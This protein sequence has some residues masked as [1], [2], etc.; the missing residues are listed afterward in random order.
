MPF[1]VFRR[2]QRKLLAVLAIFA[3][4]AFTLDLSLFR[5]RG[6]GGAGE[7]PV[8]FTIYGNPIRRS[9]M[10]GMKFERARANLFMQN[11]GAGDQFFGGTTD[12][13]IRD[14]MIL[15]H[16]ANRMKMPRS[17]DIAKLWLRDATRGQLTPELFDSIYR[18]NFTGEPPFLVSDE[19]LLGD[20]AN[21]V[22]LLKLRSL[23]VLPVSSPL[24]MD[25]SGVT[26]LDI[27]QAYR[28]QNEKVSALA[29][30][31][32]VEDYLDKVPDPKPTELQSFFDKY[33]DQL[34][35]PNRDTPGFKSPRRVKVE[36]IA[37][38]QRKLEQQYQ[39]ELT[40]DEVQQY[41]KEHADEFPA[42]PR[43]L[44][45]HL[46]A[47]DTENKLTPRTTDPFLE[48]RDDVRSRLALEKARDQTDRIFEGIREIVMDPFA[49]RYDKIV[50][51]NEVA[52]EEKRKP[53]E[54]PE[55]VASSRQTLL[56]K[57]AAEK[58]LRHEVTSLMTLTEA[59]QK[60]PIAAATLGP[61]WPSN[62]PTFS[63]FLFEPRAAVYEP[64]ELASP[65]GERFLA[66]KLA[67]Q[68][69]RVPPLADIK[70][71]VVRAWKM[72]QARKL[73][74]ADAR[75]LAAKARESKG[76][77]KAVAG[78]RPVLTTSEIPKLSPSLD[79]LSGLGL[80]GGARPS[81]IPQ[82]PNPSD[83][84]RDALFALEPGQVVVEPNAPKS[85]YY[86][87]ALQRRTPAELGNLFG[88]IGVRPRMER[89]VALNAM[90]DRVQRWMDY[91]RSRAGVT[92]TDTAKTP[93]R[94]PN[95][96]QG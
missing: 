23:P 63:E 52:K 28:D 92:T 68:E 82:I 42:P 77:L 83:A 72:Q 60:V 49:D 19:Q 56:G 69:P 10:A 27:Y 16:E 36:Y 64:F 51:E 71:R 44:P 94:A 39:N 90:R 5:N 32:S 22:R 17:P 45:E 37:V 47:G 70:D 53:A 34:D 15:E 96:R 58:G 67:D 31:V 89:E 26:P 93:D 84:L 24:D 55:P 7:D 21:Q 88:P 1:E 40:E 35:D 3:M 57:Y 25:L 95:A 79:E 81:E 20:I 73:A 9:E 8:V 80:G 12:D 2:H 38:D 18:Q 75:G 29:I 87:L 62:G 66:W 85:V 4:V 11:L 54:L 46:F 91:L 59:Q 6:P 13:E 86:V 33:K 78:S 14:A 30:P 65:G 50:E 61:T 48:V 76:D 43:E 74:E 41:Y